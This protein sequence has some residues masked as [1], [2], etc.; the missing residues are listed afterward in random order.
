MRMS[1]SPALLPDLGI[2][3]FLLGCRV[4]L[5]CDSFCPILYFKFCHVELEA[6][7][8][9]MRD[10]KGMNLDGRGVGEERRSGE[11]SIFQDKI[12]EK[13]VYFL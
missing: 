13:R 11:E 10:R 1:V 9:L 8:F 6:C 5:Q 12:Y 4:P 3:F 2:L 7:S